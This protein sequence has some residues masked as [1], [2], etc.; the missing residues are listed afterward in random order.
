MSTFGMLQAIF[1]ADLDE[2]RRLQKQRWHMLSSTRVTK[3]EHLGRCC[4]M[5]E[6]FLDPADLDLLKQ[7]IKISDGQWRAYKA[8]VSAQ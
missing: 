1:V 7:E 8:R 2:L 3:E 4:Y 6:E 5:A